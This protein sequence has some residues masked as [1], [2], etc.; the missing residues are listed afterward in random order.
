MT[1]KN[2]HAVPILDGEDLSRDHVLSCLL[3]RTVLAVERDQQWGEQW[4][5]RG[6]EGKHW[7]D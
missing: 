3:H 4:R 5:A 6:R 2:H 1:G 7:D